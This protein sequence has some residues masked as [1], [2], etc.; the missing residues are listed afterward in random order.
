MRQMGLAALRCGCVQE[1]VLWL[2]RYVASTPAEP[3]QEVVDALHEAYVKLNIQPQS[4]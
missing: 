3:E 1:A 2:Q 4:P